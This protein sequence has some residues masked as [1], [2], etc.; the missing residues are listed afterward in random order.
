MRIL[1]VLSLLAAPLLHA[2][3]TN[4]SPGD[5]WWRRVEILADDN[6]EGRL[7]G[8]PGYIKASQYVADEFARIGLKPVGRNGF[9]QA[10]PFDT[11]NIVEE[12]C[13]LEILRGNE[14][15]KLSLG[16][17]AA[18]IPT[19]DSAR[20]FNAKVA[21]VGYGLVIPEY[22]INNLAGLDLKGK[23]AVYFRGAP[24]NVPPTVVAHYSSRKQLWRN[25][26]EAGAIGLITIPTPRASDIPWDRLMQNRTQVR[27]AL[28]G[29][30]FNE[31][32]G[33]KFS[34]M[35][36]PARAD[37]LLFN[38]TGHTYTELAR[39]ADAK[40]SLPSFDLPAKIKGRTRVASDS[41]RCR[42][43]VALLEG[44]DPVLKDEYVVVTAHLDHVGTNKDLAGD[45]IYNGAL[46][47]AG[48]V[49]T[50]LEIADTLKRSG[51]NLKRSVIFLMVTGEEKGLL[52]S[53]YFASRPT[54]SREK[55]VANIN[56]DMFLPLFPLK[57]VKVLG[58]NESTLGEDVRKLCELLNLLPHDDLQPER[59]SFVRSDQYSFVR[60]GIPAVNCNFGYELNTPEHKRVQDWLKARYHGP[61]DDLS[62]P[63]NK[64]AAV[65]YND[66]ILRVLTQTAN[67]PNRPT[68][69]PDSFFRRYISQPD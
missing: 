53:R 33:L 57:H 16:T 50:W 5:S 60:Y 1:I 15:I 44:S 67:L 29:R 62:Q 46:D 52:G 36:N 66:L 8:S 13:T 42:N 55:I 61:A 18:I 25:L 59:V 64:A 10:V 43:V 22:G 28:Q 63:I 7:T 19:S 37:D 34:A 58:I 68:W 4:L 69:K 24:A 47:N 35:I 41:V 6:M 32:P 17:D 40:E 56:V 51:T 38:G 9:F 20:S 30:E 23:V 2:S 48:G 31:T 65:Q 27:M 26:R 12:K 14:T 3:V 45:G 11:H 21:F 39:R 54:V 49:S